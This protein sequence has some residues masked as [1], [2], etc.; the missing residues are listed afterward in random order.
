MGPWIVLYATH[1]CQR[2]VAPGTLAEF[3]FVLSNPC[4]IGMGNMHLAAPT[5][6]KYPTI[7]LIL[8]H[9]STNADRYADTIAA[10]VNPLTVETCGTVFWGFLHGRLPIQLHNILLLVISLGGAA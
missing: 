7:V 9:T 10:P 1:F 3:N 8:V 5:Y 4:S 6:L 2:N